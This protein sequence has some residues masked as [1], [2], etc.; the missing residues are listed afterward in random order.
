MSERTE[1]ILSQM[2][3]KEKIDMLAGADFWTTVPNERLNIPAMKV[4]DGPNGA[5]GGEF[6]MGPT[7]ACLPV[8]IAIGATWNTGLIEQLGGLLADEAKSKGA[9]ILLAPTINIHRSTLNGRN[10]ECYSEDPWLSGQMAAAYISGLQAGGIGACPKHFVANDSEFERYTMNSVVDERALREI[11]LPP[12]KAAVQEGGAWAIMSGYNKVNGVWCSENSYLLKDILKDEW[13]FDGIVMSDWF[14][15]YSSK[16]GIGGLD[17]EMPGTARHAAGLLTEVNEGRL[18]ES[19]IDDKARRMLHTLERAG[20]FENPEM[21]EEF[22][23]DRPEHRTILRQAANEAI[24]LLKNDDDLLPLTPEKAQTIAIIGGNAR[25]PGV[26]GGGSAVVP[27]HY[28]VTPLEGITARF[29]DQ[30]EL[31]YTV[32]AMSNKMLPALDKTL[33]K[34]ASG[35]QGVQIEFFDGPNLT[36]QPVDTLTK[37]RMEM[38]F[39]GN[40]NPNLKSAQNYSARITG[41]FKPVVSGEQKFS[42][43]SAGLGRMKINGETVIDNW[44]DYHP[45]VSL[46]DLEHGEKHYST[47]AKAGEALEIEVEVSSENATMMN[48][49]RFGY[50]PPLPADPIADAVKAAQDADVA[51]IFVGTNHEWETEG[52]DQDS[53]DLPGEQNA[54]ISAVAA[55]NPNTVVVL[56]T[57]TPKLLPWVDEVKSVVQ[58]WFPGQE[59]GNA[60]ADVLS[61][62]YNPSGRLPQTFPKQYEDNPS[63]LNYPGENDEVKYGEGIFVGYR[64]YERRK[65]EPLFPFGHGLSYSTFAY[66]NLKLSS[67]SLNA[68]DK[69]TVSVDVSNTGKTAGQEVVQ[70]YV[71]D[72]VSRLV[73]P[74]QELKAFAKVMLNAGETKTVELTLNKASFSYYDP[75]HNGWIAE[76]GLFEIRIGRSSANI[77]ATTKVEL[78]NPLDQPELDK[79]GSLHVGL[80]IMMLMGNPT[81]NQILSK[82]IGDLMKAPTLIFNMAKPLEQFAAE[83]PH[84]IDPRTLGRINADLVKAAA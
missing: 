75:T 47:Q 42:F 18:A 65:I 2:T 24:V 7:A 41:T 27:A 30:A 40:V 58:M 53:M 63:W 64:F 62:D 38:A 10:F 67:A 17:L 79:S 12:F 44:D 61:G 22:A 74:E 9:S 66:S 37:E 5:R 72:E 1:A 36:G 69:L 50:L 82:H 23:D 60:I 32:G 35:N 52:H 39:V 29:G 14:G 33:I 3:L 25:W 83:S 49:V 4:T 31:Q 80:P 34:T 68:G 81:S 55:A 13:G 8:G 51:V 73:R 16:I 77:V 45:G 56:N 6:G 46:F 76:S 70:L 71:R 78:I 84:L 26:M 48:M 11:Y 43:V 19:E 15:T 28:I 57:G 59:G 21:P 20:K 54:L